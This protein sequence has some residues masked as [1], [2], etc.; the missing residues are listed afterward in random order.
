MLEALNAVLELDTSD[1]LT[2]RWA[3]Q[4]HEYDRLFKENV[5]LLSF[6]A[7]LQPAALTAVLLAI[8]AR[9]ARLVVVARLPIL[10]AR[11]VPFAEAIARLKL[12]V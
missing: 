12:T 4:A 1:N 6:G 2:L 9:L 11:D 10:R 8:V 3:G 5:T 7:S